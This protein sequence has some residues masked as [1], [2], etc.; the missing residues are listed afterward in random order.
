MSNG[1]VQ[2]KVEGVI[3]NGNSFYYFYKIHIVVVCTLCYD[4]F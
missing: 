2:E 4:F 3:G 1:K